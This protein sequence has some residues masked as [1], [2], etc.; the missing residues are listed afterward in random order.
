MQD[1]GGGADF[2]LVAALVP[3][4]CCV[5]TGSDE[6]VPDALFPEEEQ[7]IARALPRRRHEFALGRT[8]ARR[9]L[10]QLGHRDACIGVRHDR[11]PL[12]PVGIVGSITHTCGLVSAVVA[13][14]DRLAGIGLD[15]ESRARPLRSGLERFILTG[16]ERRELGDALPPHLDPLRVAFSAK[17]AV[18]KCI[19]P[20]SGITLGFHDVELWFDADGGSFGAQLINAGDNRLPDFSRLYGRFVVTSAYVA[21]TVVMPAYAEAEPKKRSELR[22]V[23]ECSVVATASRA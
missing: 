19:A 20:A 15:V 17:E 2:G 3:R 12:W 1:N 5:S 16:R 9:A 8:H 10:R 11:A 4:G 21:A 13:T 23:A 18:H 7:A 22:R 6:A 14:S